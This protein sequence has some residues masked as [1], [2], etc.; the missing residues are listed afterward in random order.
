[1]KFVCGIWKSSPELHKREYAIPNFLYFSHFSEKN[2]RLD[3]KK[4]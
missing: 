4:F 2:S 3:L 1:M